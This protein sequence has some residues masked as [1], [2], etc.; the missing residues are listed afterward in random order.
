MGTTSDRSD[1]RLTHGADEEPV[2]Q[3]PVYLVMSAAEV[4]KGF[5]Q[6]VRHSY[7]HLVC[8]SVTTMR[9]DIAE[10]YA[11][12]PGFYGSTYCTTCMKHRPVGAEGEFVW[13]ENGKATD[14]KVGV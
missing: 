7:M 3:A 2:P 11:A 1:P 5:V 9:N 12:N 4:A 13:M 14:L 10:T 6:P 8:N